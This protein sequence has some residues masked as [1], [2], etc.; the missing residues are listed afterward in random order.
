MHQTGRHDIV[1]MWIVLDRRPKSSLQTDEK[2]TKQQTTSSEQQTAL[3]S[4]WLLPREV[5]PYLYS[6]PR[7]ASILCAKETHL[8]AEA[9]RTPS[10]RTPAAKTARGSRLGPA[11]LVPRNA[12]PCAAHSVCS[13]A[14]MLP[15]VLR[16][17]APLVICGEVSGT[18]KSDT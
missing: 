11:T 17:A 15:H 9:A 4:T 3:L 6:L 14:C 1:K 18:W 7:G 2:K 16:Q 12:E 5:L 10:G 8:P 13:V